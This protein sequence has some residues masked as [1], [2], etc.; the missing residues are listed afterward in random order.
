VKL[1]QLGP[2][3]ALQD[4]A[5]GAD[6]R[7]LADL[8]DGP[9]LDERVGFVARYL[10][11]MAGTEVEPRVAAST[12]SLGLFARLVA[13]LLGARA[14]GMA[15][16]ALHPEGTFWR[17]VEGGPWPLA[18]TGPATAPDPA[19]GVNEVI[20]PLA[21]VVAERFS[22]STH[23]LRGNLASAVFGA[24]RMIGAARPD[25]A[26]AAVGDGRAL[27]HGPLAGAGEMHPEFVRTSCCLY[28]RV[29]GG[30]YCGDCVLAGPHPWENEVSS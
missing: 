5:D 6:W 14:L 29:P 7:P 24:V 17:P 30:G 11:G 25:L 23:V 28:Y 26:H 2:F 1:S 3:F 15:L 22:L 21:D 18:L 16:P 13:P 27:L 12:M 19:H 4:V 8:Y 10:G 20:L 9:S